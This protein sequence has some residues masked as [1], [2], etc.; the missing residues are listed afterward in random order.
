MATVEIKMTIDM[1]DNGGNN[2]VKNDKD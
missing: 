1:N 2:N